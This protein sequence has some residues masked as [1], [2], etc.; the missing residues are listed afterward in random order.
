V[1]LECGALKVDSR[2]NGIRPVVEIWR[3]A[4]GDKKW[5]DFEALPMPDDPVAFLATWD[6]AERDSNR[7]L[8]EH[9]QSIRA[10]DEAVADLYA[11]SANLREVLRTGPLWLAG[12]EAAVA[13][14]NGDDEVEQA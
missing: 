13:E 5:N 7:L 1:R 4:Y 2:R 6:T 9:Q 12:R 14:A 10:I 11:V 8:S 3:S